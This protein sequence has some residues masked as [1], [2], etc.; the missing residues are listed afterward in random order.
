MAV[1]LKR[2][3]EANVYLNG[4][5]LLGQTEEIKLPDFTSKMSEHKAVGMVASIE[6]F[7]GI[8]KMNAEFKWNSYFPNTLAAA[9][10]PFAAVDMQVRSSLRT[11]GGAGEVTGEVPVVVY[12]KGTFSKG[13][14]G[15][16]KHHDPAD[17][18]TTMSVKY[19]RQV[20]DGKDI[21][22]IDA[23][24]NIFKVNGVDLLAQYRQNLGI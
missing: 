15:T 11:F 24:N 12:L 6:L 8:D 13:A 19:M 17:I 21:L 23:M 14:T 16:F 3:Q 5:S 1:N 18:P 4:N 9:A 10:N 22:E 20:V 7:A 2:L